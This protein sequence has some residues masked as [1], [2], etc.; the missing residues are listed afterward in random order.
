MCVCAC[1]VVVN[2]MWRLA[3]HGGDVVAHSPRSLFDQGDKAE[4]WRA[5]VIVRTV[6]AQVK[7]LVEDEQRL[8]SIGNS[9]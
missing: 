7:F 5:R 3:P 1:V 6:T 4:T 9:A 8:V 2:I